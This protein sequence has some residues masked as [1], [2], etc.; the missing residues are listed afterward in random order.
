MASAG[1]P[2]PY[3]VQGVN[4]GRR[5]E[6]RRASQSIYHTGRARPEAKIPHIFMKRRQ[7]RASLYMRSLNAPTRHPPTMEG[8]RGGPVCPAPWATR[9]RKDY[10][11][12]GNGGG[13]T[14][15]AGRKENIFGCIIVM[16]KS[17]SWVLLY[18]NGSIKKTS[19]LY[20]NINTNQWFINNISYYNVL[21]MKAF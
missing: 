8:G 14:K 21:S 5:K 16:M 10:R 1:S 15:K 17:M 9:N 4:L 3:W 11:R 2:G 6:G 18:E 20:K 19:T 13:G 7:D 12:D